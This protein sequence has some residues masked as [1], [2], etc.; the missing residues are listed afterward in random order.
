VVDDL[1]PSRSAVVLDA[2]DLDNERAV[3]AGL[4]SSGGS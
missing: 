1:R 3:N 2:A 4:S